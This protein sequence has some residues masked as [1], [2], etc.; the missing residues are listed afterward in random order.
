[1]DREKYLPLG[2]LDPKVDLRDYTYEPEIA[3]AAELPEE[4]ELWTPDIKNQGVV[5]S[6]VAHTAAEIEEYFN[7]I[8]N[9]PNKELSVGYIY[10]C[11]YNYKGEGMYLRDALKTLKNR[12]VVEKY[13]FPYNKEVPVII[14]LFEEADQLG[15]ETD[16][17]HKITS[18]F[19]I[20]GKG[21]ELQDKVKRCL[22]N[23]G[24]VMMSVPWYKDFEV[25]NGI[26]TSP[27]NMNCSQGGHCILLYGW[28]K[29]GWLIQNSWG[30]HWGNG[31]RATYPYDYPV[32]EF[33][34]VTD[35]EVGDVKKTDYNEFMTIVIKV[36][37]GIINFFRKLTFKK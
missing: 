12:G 35:T 28:N 15:W 16:K 3:M 11:R 1:M 20:N 27:S 29:D 30:K 22:M 23:N 13:E 10:G 9:K 34:G 7:H 4:F 17:N 25:V 14:T 32:K 24:P 2:A 26:I 8:E 37:N 33:W 18:Y 5:G 6:C 36:I 31:G 21:E 19:S